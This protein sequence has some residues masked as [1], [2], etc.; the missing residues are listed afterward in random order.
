MPPSSRVHF[1][2]Y[3]TN[4]DIVVRIISVSVFLY[5]IYR[6]LQEPIIIFVEF[7]TDIHSYSIIWID[8]KNAP[9]V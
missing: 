5:C 9:R 7:A 3:S 4:T 2:F 6:I 1:N 8:F